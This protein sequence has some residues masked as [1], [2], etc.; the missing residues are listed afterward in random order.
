LPPSAAKSARAVQ[1]ENPDEVAFVEPRQ[2]PDGRFNC[3]HSC[4]SSRRCHLFSLFAD[5]LPFSDDKTSCKHLWYAHL[6]PPFFPRRA[7]LPPFQSCREGLDKP[8]RRRAKATVAGGKASKKAKTTGPTLTQAFAGAAAESNVKPLRLP[9]KTSAGVTLS[10][11]SG[12]KTKATAQGGDSS[13]SDLDELLSLDQVVSSSKPFG[14]L[15]RTFSSSNRLFSPD[16]P[17]PSYLDQSDPTNAQDDLFSSPSPPTPKVPASASASVRP[18]KRSIEGSLESKKRRRFSLREFASSSSLE[19]DAP[20]EGIV[21]SSISKTPVDEDSLFLPSSP[22]LPA[23]TRPAP[24]PAQ[25]PDP[26]ASLSSSAL[27][28]PEPAQQRPVSSNVGGVAEEELDE[29]EEDEA[30]VAASVEK[31]V[32]GD[33]DDDFDAWLEQNVVVHV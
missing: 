17:K 23:P 27:H 7:D 13:D 11:Q 6:C 18:S 25:S 22:G 8:P 15:R 33:D 31:G 32:F 24:P 9:G 26:F 21:S 20:A 3:N 12:G 28:W 2:R 16:P 30:P 4:R 1:E 10:R 5:L 29:F 14:T 19:L